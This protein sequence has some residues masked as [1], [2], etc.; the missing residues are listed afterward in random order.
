MVLGTPSMGVDL[1]EILGDVSAPFPVRSPSLPLLL[2]AN[3][4]AEVDLSMFRAVPH[5]HGRNHWGVGGRSG[6][7][8]FLHSFLINTV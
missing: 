3:L 5:L 7:L 1:T 4:L 2:L 8:D 6:P